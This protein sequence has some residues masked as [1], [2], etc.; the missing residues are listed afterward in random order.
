MNGPLV[1][2]T[3]HSIFSWLPNINLIYKLS[4]PTILKPDNGRLH[5]CL[6]I[7]SLGCY[8]TKAFRLVYHQRLCCNQKLRVIEL[9]KIRMTELEEVYPFCLLPCHFQASEN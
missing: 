7:A 9:V 5:K 8:E 6:P 3:G 2:T 4:V 1:L